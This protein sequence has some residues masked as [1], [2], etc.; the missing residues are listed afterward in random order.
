[1]NK[2]YRGLLFWVNSF[3][4]H[5]LEM[6]SEI[7]QL[8]VAICVKKRNFLLKIDEEGAISAEEF[9]GLYAFCM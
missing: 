5:I 3:L 7:R 8:D 1:M 6:A 4:G 9:C 2:L